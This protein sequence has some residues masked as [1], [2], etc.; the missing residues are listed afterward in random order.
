MTKTKEE[1]FEQ[2]AMLEAAERATRNL[3]RQLE[4]DCA[5]YGANQ[6][7]LGRFTIDNLRVH[8]NIHKEQQAKEQA[9]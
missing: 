2:L 5:A 3:R 6:R 8:Y 7:Y 1:L 9:A 4:E